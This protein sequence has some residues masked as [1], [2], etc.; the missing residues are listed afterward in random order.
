MAPYY[1]G[2][3]QV[4]ALG[5]QPAPAAAG[6]PERASLEQVCGRPDL[7]VGLHRERDGSQQ[8]AKLREWGLLGAKWCPPH[9]V[10]LGSLD[11]SRVS[12]SG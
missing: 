6:V 3:E 9:M 4:E 1:R 12:E 8:I 2:V 11:D 5:V 7:Q 10:A